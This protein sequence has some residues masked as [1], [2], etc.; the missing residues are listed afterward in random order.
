MHEWPTSD[1]HILAPGPD[2]ES[3]ACTSPSEVELGHFVTA[4]KESAD[5]LVES[6]I[7]R[8]AVLDV[9][10]FPILFLYR[11][12]LE[13]ELKNLVMIHRKLLG[14][15]PDY[16]Q[17]HS[18]KALWDEAKTGIR[19]DYGADCPVE[20]DYLDSCIDELNA[21]DPASFSFRY[22][23]DRKKLVVSR[24]PRLVNVRELRD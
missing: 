16:P 1:V 22:P 20:V 18:L 21:H 17:H 3:N 5:A 6:A 7:A 4:Y 15:D 23:R 9:V 12:Y 11:H 10:L 14:A 19:E 13:L 24:L 8:R 2:I